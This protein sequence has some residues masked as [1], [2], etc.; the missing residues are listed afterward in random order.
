MRV[1]LLS[2]IESV[3]AAGANP[4][5]YLSVAGRAI[6]QHQLECAIALGCEKIACQASG[7][8][9][10]LLALQHLAETSGVQFQVISGSRALSGMVRADD[11]LLVIADGVLPDQALAEKLLANRPAIFVLPADEGIAAGFE[12]IDR[13]HAW[14]GLLMVRGPAVERLADLPPDADPIAGLLRIALQSGTRTVP[15][16]TGVL[17]ERQWGLVQ[18]EPDAADFEKVWLERNVQ[19]AIFIAPSLAL[20]DRIA[21]RLMKG[22]GG[23]KIGS[24]AILAGAAGLGVIAGFTGW[25]WQPVAGIALMALAYLV[26][27]IGG[28]LRSIEAIGRTRQQGS[29]RTASWLGI[30]FDILL[31]CLS[32]FDSLA[33]E[34][35]SAIFGVAALLVALRLGE[36]LPLHKW[37]I[38]FADRTLLAIALASAA[39]YSQL[40]VVSELLTVLCLS[41]ILLETSRSKITR[42]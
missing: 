6:V 42:T 41:A 25:L 17:A 40:I 13:E 38:F 21:I 7:L 10:E 14:A 8:P 20:A 34:R 16:P 31:V 11:E 5:G 1:A 23:R 24:N 33:S 30:A 15:M 19:P 22:S 32:G 28:A 36:A 9:Q 18:S 39:N 3:S 35:L 37:K 4:R 2:T 27:R 12:R 26:V 29:G